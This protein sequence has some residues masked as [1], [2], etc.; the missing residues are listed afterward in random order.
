GGL[1]VTGTSA[2]TLSGANDYT[3]DTNVLGGSLTVAGPVGA[4]AGNTIV[5][6]GASLTNAGTVQQV[7]NAGTFANSGVAGNVT[8]SNL[9][10]NSGTMG[11]VSNSGTLTNTAAGVTSNVGNTGTLINNGTTGAVTN[12]N[13]AT[14]NGTMGSVSNSGTLTNTSSGVTG[15]VTNTGTASN[16]GT[17]ASL[18]QQAGSFTNTN[19][20]TGDA[21]VTG[22]TLD[23][24]GAINGALRVAAGTTANVTSGSVAGTTT[25]TG[26]A[27]NITNGN[28]TG[29]VTNNGG[30]TTLDGGSFATGLNNDAGSL[31]AKGAV[32]GDITNAALLT[33]T[34]PD[35]LDLTGKITNT[36]SGTFTTTGTTTTSGGVANSGIVNAS[37]ALNSAVTN[38]ATF[39]V[40]GPLTA[41]GQDFT[42]AAN[43]NIGANSYTGIGTLT[44][45]AAGVVAL[46]ATGRLGTVTLTNNGTVNANSATV[47][48]AIT[49]N[50]TFNARSAAL[51]GSVNNAAA[52]VFDLTG[53]SVTG[54]VTN[55]GSFLM[56]NG[57]VSGIFSNSG[58]VT[59]LGLTSLGGLSNTGAGNI[60]LLTPD[61]G[62]APQF[63][64]NT[65][66]RLTVNGP[67]NGGNFAMDLN[68]GSN[69]AIGPGGVLTNPTGG[70]SDQIVVNG[71]ISGNLNFDFTNKV[72]AGVPPFF[73][74]A[75]YVLKGDRASDY[76]FTYS[77]LGQGGAVVYSLGKAGNDL[78]IVSETSAGIGGIAA[79]ASLVQSLI[80]TVVNRPTSPFV[81]GLATE[82]GCSRGGYFRG[83]YGTSTVSGTSNNG[84]STSGTSL[85][86]R[87]AGVQGGYD[88][89]CNDGRFFDG[90]DGSFGAMLGYNNGRSD[91]DVNIG[92]SGGGTAVASVT[93]TKF[94]QKYAGVYAA[95]SKDRITADV[96]LRFEKSNFTLNETINPGF[97]GLGLSNAKFGTNSVNVTGRVSYRMDLGKEGLNFVPTAGLSYTH[98]SA[99]TVNFT[100]GENLR[101]DSFN[102]IVGFVGGT[103][104]KTTLAPEGNA[105]TTFFASANYYNDFAGDR[106]SVFTDRLGGTQNITTKNIGGFGEL[107]MGV[108]YVRI[109]DNGPGGAKQL[110][111]N[112]RLDGRFGK[113]VKGSTSITA[114]VRLSF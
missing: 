77:G 107:S 66:D 109:L 40:T 85:R 71:A 113:N 14:N 82:E 29:A 95:F 69:N 37:G 30:T 90:W 20:I 8:N 2:T 89:G 88:Y 98:T 65:Q 1:N 7:I 50:M 56:S 23:H 72:V 101:T 22:G 60:S 38:N 6:L 4:I 110:N 39:N 35:T 11:V 16:A 31:T 26:G 59:A 48:G 111:A 46:D 36:D 12:S 53:G 102:S 67:V 84:V 13:I 103:I 74:G 43:L 78:Q 42:N 83:T 21:V 57:A 92:V 19:I 3:G 91:Q 108:N 32:T 9:T 87:Y 18:A 68:L 47:S 28:F 97:F 17:V 61:L 81:S 24:S 106:K 76:S 10:T 70:T 79:N 96:Q 41:T 55:A 33:V 25:N 5:A 34:A 15:P 62:G 51:S 105:G 52:G 94:D 86:A 49:N 44:N 27:L 45:G 63:D 54:P 93:N 75:I 80:G 73:G 99:A 104:A 58:Q 100:G 114:Q 64:Q 112:L